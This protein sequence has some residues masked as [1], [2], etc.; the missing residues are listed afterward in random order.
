MKYISAFFII[1]TGIL[2]FSTAGMCQLCSTCNEF[3]K[4]CVKLDCDGKLGKKLR[5]CKKRAQEDCKFNSTYTDCKKHYC[6]EEDE[7]EDEDE[8]TEQKESTSIF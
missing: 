4:D 5:K 3:F 2:F 1:G 7:D 8:K 6:H